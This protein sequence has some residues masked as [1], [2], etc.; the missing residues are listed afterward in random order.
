M[1]KMKDGRF[2]AQY[3]NKTDMLL[4]GIEQY[5][6]TAFEAEINLQALINTIRKEQGKTN[7]I[8]YL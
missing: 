6:K 8:F 3:L 2:S 5:G 1:R 7:V 4:H